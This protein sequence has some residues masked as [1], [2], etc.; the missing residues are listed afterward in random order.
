MIFDRSNRW[1]REAP[2]GTLRKHVDT[3]SD[4]PSCHP[5]HLR[6]TISR[7]LA[8]EPVKPSLCTPRSAP[9]AGSAEAPSRSSRDCS[10]R[11]ARTAHWWSP[12]RP[13]TSRTRRCGA[14]RR[15]PRSGGRPSGRPCPHTTPCH[16]HA[17][18]RRRPGD[19]PR[20]GRAPCAARI[21]RRPSPR[22]ARARRRSSTGHA[23]D[24]RLGERSPL[25]RL[26]ELHARVLLLG[27]GYD[28]CTGFHLA[29]YRI[30]SPLVKVGRPGPGAAGRW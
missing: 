18:G 28:A 26:E 23:P 14:T 30:P 8:S 12:P 15:C 29:E 21:P 6:R 9:S 17:R 3:P 22:S 16:P 20:P 11:S 13:E 27:A 25:A 5:G 1:R 4:R 2:C 7:R 10:T 24:C 19:R